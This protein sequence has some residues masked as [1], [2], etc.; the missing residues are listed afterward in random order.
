M[1]SFIGEH[2]MPKTKTPVNVTLDTDLV[3]AVDALASTSSRSKVM[4]DLLRKALQ[5]SEPGSAPA[6]D[7]TA[8]RAMILKDLDK[9]AER[10]GRAKILKCLQLYEQ[11]FNGPY[12]SPA[13]RGVDV[14]I[15]KMFQEAASIGVDTSALVDFRE[16]V[17]LCKRLVEVEEQIKQQ[18]LRSASAAEAAPAT[19]ASLV[20]SS[21][22]EQEAASAEDE[23]MKRGRVVIKKSRGHLYDYLRYRDAEGKERWKC[24]GRTSPERA[25]EHRRR[26]DER[27]QKPPT[28]PPATSTSPT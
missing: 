24:L 22:V 7:P 10:A 20:A 26:R 17:E 14:T 21:V 16:W 12:I 25:A 9:V 6:V 13:N 23:L 19:P 4:N 11:R 1:A 18:V 28:Q 27:Q 3:T 2:F 5:G 15:A 8:M